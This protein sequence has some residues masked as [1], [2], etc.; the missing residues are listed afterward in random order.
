MMPLC[1]SHPTAASPSRNSKVRVFIRSGALFPRTQFVLNAST[2]DGRWRH[3]QKTAVSTRIAR[4]ARGP[5][6]CRGFH[7]IR[8]SVQLKTSS[9]NERR[10]SSVPLSATADSA[11]SIAVGPRSVWR[12]IYYHRGRDAGCRGLSRINPRHAEAFAGGIDRGT[13][14]AGDQHRNLFATLSSFLDD[15]ASFLSCR[16]NLEFARLSALLTVALL[17][18]IA[19]VVT[20]Y[21]HH[22]IRFWHSF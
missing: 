22:L 19:Y 2:A 10:A 7:Q 12:S 4:I 16:V 13:Q 18:S 1:I 20:L 9:S 21:S 3:A 8:T 15:P 17:L 14:C 5:S 6:P 11:R